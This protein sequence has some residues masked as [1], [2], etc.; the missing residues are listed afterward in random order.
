VSL[1]TSDGRKHPTYCD[2]S[3]DTP[4]SPFNFTCF[5]NADIDEFDYKNKWAM[6]EQVIKWAERNIK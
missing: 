6:S 5:E 3:R 4:T 2:L 1:V